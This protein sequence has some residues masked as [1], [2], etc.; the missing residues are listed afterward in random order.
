MNQT[1]VHE[2]EY[3]DDDDMFDLQ[4]V[5]VV[6][7]NVENTERMESEEDETYLYFGKTD[8]DD[9]VGTDNTVEFDRIHEIQMEKQE[10]IS[11]QNFDDINEKVVLSYEDKLLFAYHQDTDVILLGDEAVNKIKVLL[12]NKTS[13]INGI[14]YPNSSFFSSGKNKLHLRMEV[15]G[16]VIDWKSRYLPHLG[17]LKFFLTNYSLC[18]KLF[19]VVCS[20]DQGPGML[21]RQVSVENSDS[22]LSDDSGDG[23]INLSIIVNGV[24]MPF[25]SDSDSNIYNESSD[26]DDSYV[27]SF[28][29]SKTEAVSSSP[30]EIELRNE[31][32][33][34]AIDELSNLLQSQIT[35]KPPFSM[36]LSLLNIRSAWFSKYSPLLGTMKKWISS[37]DHL[38]EGFNCPFEILSTDPGCDIVKL[39]R[40]SKYS[41]DSSSSE[42]SLSGESEAVGGASVS[43]SACTIAKK[44][45]AA[46]CEQRVFYNNGINK[47]ASKPYSP[48]DSHPSF[49]SSTH[50]A[51][52]QPP[53]MQFKQ[54][55][56]FKNATPISIQV[57]NPPISHLQ[58][59]TNNYSRNLASS[60][61]HK[62]LAGPSPPFQHAPSHYSSAHTHAHTNMMVGIQ[63]TDFFDISLVSDPTEKAYQKSMMRIHEIVRVLA[64]AGKLQD[65]LRY[66]CER[67]N[68][69]EWLGD[70]VLHVEMSRLL[71]A[72]FGELYEVDGLSARR[73]NA[74]QRLTLGLLF[75]ECHIARYLQVVPR[76][77]TA[78]SWKPKCDIIEAIVGELNVRMNDASMEGLPHG[79]ELRSAANRLISLFAQAAL[80]RGAKLKSNDERKDIERAAHEAGG[81]GP[82]ITPDDQDA[83][84]RT[85]VQKYY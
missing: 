59:G 22:N 4:R 28:A 1:Q 63:L 81:G 16:N 25:H 69:L 40:F 23:H 7:G 35:S 77:F 84:D 68:M 43:A 42:D 54:A 71:V 32:S 37:L 38:K 14:Y 53:P 10:E 64:S 8:A 48:Q 27:S 85:S 55:S 5:E 6:A 57:H 9:V 19:R 33:R 62:S 45:G 34:H 44:V 24:P 56:P 2:F 67:F 30:E 39:K 75:D 50:E 15:L 17:K 20:P 58:Q 31:R 78:Q 46:L 26:D 61:V 13:G 18:I 3:S 36:K 73:Q 80:E 51:H 74:E 72:N 83:I 65:S 12:H 82:N 21:I 29:I 60:Y 79:H 11:L 70:A 76:S 47:N 52:Q 41:S 49:L 66:G